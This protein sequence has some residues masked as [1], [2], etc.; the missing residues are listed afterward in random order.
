MPYPIEYQSLRR[1]WLG[2][3]KENKLLQEENKALKEDVAKFLEE[4]REENKALKEDI[5]K[6]QYYV[7]REEGE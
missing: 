2:K 7:D 3:V 6:L 5:A 1:A 4:L